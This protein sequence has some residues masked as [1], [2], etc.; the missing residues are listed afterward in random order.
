MD[1]M[2]DALRRDSSPAYDAERPPGQL[3]Y[4]EL[5]PR[6]DRTALFE[7]VR[8]V[9]LMRSWQIVADSA[10]GFDAHRRS[11]DIDARVRVFL[12]G[13]ELRYT[14]D[15]TVQNGAQRAM[16]PARWIATLRTDLRTALAPMTARAES[17]APR[18]GAVQR[19][20][21][22]PLE[23]LRTL[24]ALLD[25]GLITPAEYE[26]KRTEILKDL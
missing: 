12:F 6:L 8:N 1:I 3:L 22:D 14:D 18:A 26:A 15:S 24:K 10:E 2:R 7:T 19:D 13:N 5:S 17:Q 23:R 21:R 25:S 4:G 20:T 9:F 16:A 11:D